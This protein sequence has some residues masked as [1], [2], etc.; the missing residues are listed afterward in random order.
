M[1]GQKMTNINHTIE[2]PEWIDE[3]SPMHVAASD[4]DPIKIIELLTK[5][6]SSNVINDQGYTALD[7]EP[8][9]DIKTLMIAAGGTYGSYLI[10]IGI[11]YYS[12][13]ADRIDCLMDDFD[14]DRATHIVDELDAIVKEGKTSYLDYD[15]IDRFVHF[16]GFFYEAEEAHKVKASGGVWV[17]DLI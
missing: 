3:N 17:G 8:G 12:S 2:C 5:G 15:R 7:D 14:L 10:E 6:T 11:D 13:R 16:L 1:K 9:D 4:G